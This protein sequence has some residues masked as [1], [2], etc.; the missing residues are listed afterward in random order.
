MSSCWVVLCFIKSPISPQRTQ[1]GYC[2]AFYL[3]RLQVRCFSGLR[4]D[5]TMLICM[6]ITGLMLLHADLRPGRNPFL[7]KQTVSSHRRHNEVTNQTHRGDFIPRE[8]A[9]RKLGEEEEVESV[10]IDTRR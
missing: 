7:M 9:H 6:A 4:A 8:D 2:A 5:M 1:Q 3:K 10:L